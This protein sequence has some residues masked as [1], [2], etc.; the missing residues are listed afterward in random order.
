MSLVLAAEVTFA[1]TIFTATTRYRTV[2]APACP[3][4]DTDESIGAHQAEPDRSAP[5]GRTC[6]SDLR[7]CPRCVRL[8]LAADPRAAGDDNGAGVPPSS[9]PDGQGRVGGGACG[10]EGG[11]SGLRRGERARSGGVAWGGSFRAGGGV[12]TSTALGRWRRRL[13][14]SGMGAGED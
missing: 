3:L 9:F 12:W 5:V 8:G 10:V 13:I 2:T 4:C 6:C 1:I 7:P 11:D 14:R